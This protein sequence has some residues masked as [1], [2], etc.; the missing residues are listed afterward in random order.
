MTR[1]DLH[2]GDTVFI[3]K[4]GEIIP[5]ITGVDMSFRNPEK[6]IFTFPSN[7]PDCNSELV[8]VEGE[9]NHYCM[10]DSLCPT[11]IKGKIEHFIQRKALNIENIGVETIDLLFAKSKKC[12]VRILKTKK[13]IQ[14]VYHKVVLKPKSKKIKI[15]IEMRYNICH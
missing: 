4:G 8:R 5:K 10:N 11:Q 9:A 2:E 7:C 1:L 6:P 14:T 15:L 13:Q 12:W 3:E